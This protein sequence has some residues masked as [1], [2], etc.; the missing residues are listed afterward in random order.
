VKKK[1]SIIVAAG[2]S[3]E[4]ISATAPRGDLEFPAGDELS[5]RRRIPAPF[6]FRRKS[7]S[8]PIVFNRILFDSATT[9][10]LHPVV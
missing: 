8:P 3:P 9:V 7:L 2:S 6:D 1:N 5:A 4:G 10:T